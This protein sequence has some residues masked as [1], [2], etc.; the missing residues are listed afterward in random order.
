[1]IRIDR[2]EGVP[3]ANSLTATEEICTRC[4]AGSVS[5]T[6]HD[7]GGTPGMKLFK[8]VNVPVARAAP[9]LASC[10]VSPDRVPADR[11]WE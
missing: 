11:N 3:K 10:T 9:V 7:C 1:V 2:T 6:G 4:D 5:R 8:L